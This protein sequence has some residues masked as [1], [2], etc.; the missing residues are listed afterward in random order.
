MLQVEANWPILYEFIL[1][2]YKLVRFLL[3]QANHSP[4]ERLPTLGLALPQAVSEIYDS[5]AQIVTW[6]LVGHVFVTCTHSTVHFVT[7][8][9]F[10]KTRMRISSYTSL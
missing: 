4:L 8:A 9:Q 6:F 2:L 3:N 7:C 10:I 1:W 5:C